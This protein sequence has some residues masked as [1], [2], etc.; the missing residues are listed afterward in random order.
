MLVVGLVAYKSVYIEKLSERISKSPAK[1]DPAAFSK[2]LWEE[3]LPARMDSAVS[4]STLIESVAKDKEAGIARY[5]NALAIGNYR[6][7]LVNTNAIVDEVGEDELQLSL[8]HAD[9]VLHIKLATEFIYGNAVRDASGLVQVKDFPN[10][11]ELNSISEELNKLV[12]GKVI[13]EIKGKL[14]KG[15]R[16]KIVAA[17]EINKEHIHWQ[18]MNSILS[19]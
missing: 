2:K 19:V 6:Y 11:S 5:T 4:L 9:S 10:T 12:R 8:N 16:L 17:M 14:K 1:F 13:P 18:G 7:A 3:Q 15:D